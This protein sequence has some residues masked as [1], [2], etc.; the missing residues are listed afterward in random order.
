MEKIYGQFS[1]DTIQKLADIVNT[2]EL[3]EITIADGDKSI[4]IK[5]RKCPPPPR[6]DDRGAPPVPA[7]QP[8]P[9]KKQPQEPP[10]AD[11]N[12]VRSPIV[13]T[14]YA[15]PSPDRPP[16]VRVGQHVRRGDVLMIIESMK[17]MNEIQSPFDGEV[18]QIMLKNGAAVEYDQPIM[19]I[20]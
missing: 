7:G 4:T 20:G 11:G 17:V 3:S 1:L 13:G 2:N 15:S 18:K 6:D 16:F 19:I 14:F 10:V 8:A 9:E 5:G 12:V